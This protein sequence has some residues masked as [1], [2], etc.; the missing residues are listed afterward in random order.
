MTRVASGS[1]L[2][3]HVLRSMRPSS[4]LELAINEAEKQ[5]KVSR[6]QHEQASK[7]AARAIKRQKAGVRAARKSAATAK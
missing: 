6:R 7:R 5:T 2:Y 3:F 4:R 1:E